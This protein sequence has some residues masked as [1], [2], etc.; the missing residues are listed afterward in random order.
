M[1][2]QGAENLQSFCNR[3]PRQIWQGRSGLILRMG[4]SAGLGRLRLQGR[5]GADGAGRVPARV[6]PPGLHSAA[7]AGP[8]SMCR[9]PGFKRRRLSRVGSDGDLLAW[10]RDAGNPVEALVQGLLQYLHFLQFAM[11]QIQ[12]GVVV[13]VADPVEQLRLPGMCGEAA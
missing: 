1:P 6:L 4:A 9:P 3:S 13:E 10:L 5:H 2:G 7:D 12:F 8:L 11:H